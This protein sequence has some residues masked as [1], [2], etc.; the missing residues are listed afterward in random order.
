MLMTI[1]AGALIALLAG[2]LIR[3]LLVYLGSTAQIT[4]LEFA[5]GAAICALVVVPA[6]SVVGAK[7]AKASKLSYR[8]FWSGYET[9]AFT[10]VNR[11]SKTYEYSDC[12]HSYRCDPVHHLH[13]R[14]VSDG[15]DANGNPKTRTETYS[16]THW[17]YC[18]EVTHEIDYYVDTTLGKYTIATDLAPPN[19][20]EHEWDRDRNLPQSVIRDA[21]IPPFWAQAKRRLSSGDPGPATKVMPYD[22][23]ILAS[24]KTILKQWS[25]EME[26]YE[27][28]GLLPKVSKETYDHYYADKAYFVGRAPGDKRAWRDAVMRFNGA[29][30]TTLQGDLH[31]VVVSSRVTDPDEYFGALA[32]YWQSPAMG[33]HA[34]SKN[35][36]LVAV[37]SRDG[38]VIDWARAAT[39]MPMGNEQMIQAVQTRLKGAP[40]EPEALFGHPKARLVPDPDDK[41]EYDAEVSVGEGLLASVI[42]SG[43]T[44]FDRVC[45][46]CKDADDEGVGFGYLGGDIQPSTG[47]KVA[48]FFVALFFCFMVWGAF[49]ALGVPAGVRSARSMYDRRRSNLN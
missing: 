18:P 2:L 16:E 38:K 39:G 26:Q 3:Y 9:R 24:Q 41:G 1:L 4:W 20:Y 7:M 27:R 43:P 29:L 12:S 6:V 19:P 25:A 15:T 21:Y 45:M 8:E 44:Q 28:A 33:K 11:C 46:L 22:N 47:H 37:G 40:L 48:I 32:A 23:Y 13:T 5:V 42:L 36:I 35:G 31:F 30:G 49:A 17:H 10:T 14:T 34:L